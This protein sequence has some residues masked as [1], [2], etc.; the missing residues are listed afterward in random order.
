MKVSPGA[1]EEILE[2]IKSSGISRGDMIRMGPKI[3]EQVAKCGT[4]E[5]EFEEQMETSMAAFD[6]F[7]SK[8][9]FECD[10]EGCHGSGNE[11][12]WTCR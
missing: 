3:K 9:C 7:T 12:C 5:E 10:T 6:K 2:E 11:D 8:S 4:S 1:M